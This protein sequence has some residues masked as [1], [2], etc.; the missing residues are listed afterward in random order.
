MINEK[1]LKD[2][3]S[4]KKQVLEKYGD[5]IKSII[6]AG[7]Y[8]RGEPQEESDIDFFIILDDTR[9]EP[10]RLSEIGDEI[11]KIAK[12]VSE[13][14]SP[15]GWP[16]VTSTEFIEYAMHAHP[17]VY[18][19]LKEGIVIYDTGFFT[20]W[21]KLLKSGKISR[22]RE[23]IEKYMEEA[24]KKLTRARTV[25]LLI[26]GEDC[27]YAILNTAQAILMSMGIEPPI[28]SKSYGEVKKHLVESGL[29]E[30]EYAEWLKEIVEI[31]KQ[32]EHK[33]LIDIA[34]VFVDEWIVR[35]EKFGKRM[36]QLLNDLQVKKRGDT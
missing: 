21:Q 30:P 19:I 17:I 36:Q 22:T 4:F 16:P 7:S 12:S 25:K 13:N 10:E 24:Q 9:M 27:Y 34:G 35:A 11:L 14:I 18:N 32:I 3:L 1:V 15:L 29:L 6:I 8:A 23:A 26:V 5:L 28:P 31:R 33:N 2:V 20:P